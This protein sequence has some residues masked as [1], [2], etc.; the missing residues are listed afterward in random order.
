MALTADDLRVEL[1]F[2]AD[3]WTAA[4]ESRAGSILRR[5]RVTVVGMVGA[6]RLARAE[7][8]ASSSIPEIA[9]RGKAKLAAIDE[10]VLEYAKARFGNPERVMQRREG[11]DNSV[12]FADSSDAATGRREAQAIVAGAFGTRAATTTT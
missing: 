10:A 5:S 1:G 6:G 8:D 3:E 12:S 4:D 7:A 2:S 11:A 9:A